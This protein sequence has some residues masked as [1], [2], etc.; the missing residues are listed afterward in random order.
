[1]IKAYRI[2]KVDRKKLELQSVATDLAKK[3]KIGLD[4]GNRYVWPI[5]ENVETQCGVCETK[6]CETCRRGFWAYK[7]IDDIKIS[8]I[9]DDYIIGEVLLY[10]RIVEHEKGYRAEKAKPLSIIDANVKDFGIIREIADK[11]GMEIKEKKSLFKKDLPYYM[12]YALILISG[13]T[14]FDLLRNIWINIDRPHLSPENRLDMWDYLSYLV[15]IGLMVVLTWMCVYFIKKPKRL[16]NQ[17]SVSH[18]SR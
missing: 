11:Y 5:G 17:W 3:L 12:W 4:F 7:S 1:M 8:G 9:Y 18:E 16:K 14:L 2:W 13:Y 6:D 10:G 15:L